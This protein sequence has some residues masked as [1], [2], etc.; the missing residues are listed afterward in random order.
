[1]VGMHSQMGWGIELPGPLPAAAK[2][3]NKP[4][5][6]QLE[7]MDGFSIANVKD[8]IGYCDGSRMIDSGKLSHFF[9]KKRGYTQK[10]QQKSETFHFRPLMDKFPHTID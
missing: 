7:K 9:W 8:R 3:L 5:R 10:E 2:L 6:I 1:M 4:E